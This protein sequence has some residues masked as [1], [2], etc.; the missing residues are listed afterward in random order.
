MSLENKYKDYF[1][2]KTNDELYELLNKV[3]FFIDISLQ[4]SIS[5]TSDERIKQL[6]NS[7]LKIRDTLSFE[8]NF[9]SHRKNLLKMEEDF[10]RFKELNEDQ[11]GNLK[12]N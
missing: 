5:G 10:N 4:E 3:K 7:F 12:K 2:K 6:F 11:E 8:L 1:K 9:D